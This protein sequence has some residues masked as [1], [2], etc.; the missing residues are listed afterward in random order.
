[1]DYNGSSTGLA[2]ILGELRA[3]SRHQTQTIGHVLHE[4]QRQNAILLDLPSRISS[5]IA[6]PQSS[7]K[8]RLLPEV[9]D[10]LRA[11]YPLLIL[12][13]AMFGKATWPTALPLIRSVLEVAATAS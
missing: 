12:A 3:E 6:T 9:S 11:L 7:P 5:A 10:L 13:T 8:P 4:I 1:M 2:I